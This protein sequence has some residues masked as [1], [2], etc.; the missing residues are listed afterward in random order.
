MTI[1][2]FVLILKEHLLN[3]QIELPFRERKLIR[4]LIMLFDEIDLNGNGLLEWDEFTNYIIE[5]ATVLNNIKHKSDEVKNYTPAHIKI[6]KKFPN[7]LTKA[8]YIEEIDR[9]AIL[10]EGT[11]EI[12]F[13]NHDTGAINDKKLLVRAPPDADNKTKVDANDHPVTR[14]EKSMVLD[15]IYIRDKD[16]NYLMT[17]SNDGAIRT[18]RNSG[19]GFILANAEEEAL[20]YPQAQRVMAWD[21]VNQVLFTGQRD[22]VIN[23][24]DKK[25]VRISRAI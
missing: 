13:I 12:L 3:W 15:M 6:G 8:V 17:S 1:V 2:D 21:E 16:S 23:I 5:K 14:A 9:I 20:Y 25:S 4:V 24:W 7:L 10:E 19:T 18:W 11:D 22:G